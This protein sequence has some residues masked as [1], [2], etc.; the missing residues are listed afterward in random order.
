[1]TTASA[2]APARRGRARLR[3][4]DAAVDLIRARGLH[5]TTVD[6]LCSAA[7]VTKGAFFHHFETK[8]ALAVAAAQHW[9]E[10]TGELFANADYHAHADPLDRILGYLDLRVVLT[11]GTTEEYTCLVGTMV[12]EAYASSPAVRAACEATIFGHATFLE[13]EFREAISRHGAPAG[14]TARSLAIHTQT[15]LQGAFVLAKASGDVAV[16]LDSIE[17][18][19]RYVEQLFRPAA[20][21]TTATTTT[22]TTKE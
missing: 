5:A 20:I 15:V 19:R 10:T 22:A 17:H 7:G 8:E 21:T 11:E 16:V 2:P 13:P 3:L 4:L 6:D 18:L 14:V 12:Q 1:M 9:H